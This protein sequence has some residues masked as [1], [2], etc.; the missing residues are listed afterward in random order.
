MAGTPGWPQRRRWRYNNAGVEGDPPSIALA[1]GRRELNSD[2]C[3]C[4][5]RRLRLSDEVLSR[6][7]SSLLGASAPPLCG[8]H[9][10]HL[11]RTRGSRCGARGQ[12][13]RAVTTTALSATLPVH[14]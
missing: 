1:H 9:R 11:A 8:N 6:V 4:A 14:E 7:R 13:E 2:C 5:T 12:H 3:G 10:A